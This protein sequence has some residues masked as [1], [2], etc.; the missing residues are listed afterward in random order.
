M[1]TVY[2]D[3]VRA[4]FVTLSKLKWLLNIASRTCP[5]NEFFLYNL[6]LTKKKKKNKFHHKPKLLNILIN[7]L[8]Y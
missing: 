8:N 7:M 3:F 4:D 6:I 1:E 5:R 2:K